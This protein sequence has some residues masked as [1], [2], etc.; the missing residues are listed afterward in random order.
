MRRDLADEARGGAAGRSKAF[1]AAA[2][3]DATM[4]AAPPAAAR[5]DACGCETP[6]ATAEAAL[7]AEAERE[8]AKEE[9]RLLGGRVGCG[10]DG[11]RGAPWRESATEGFDNIDGNPSAKRA[12]APLLITPSSP[13]MYS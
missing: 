6:L 7:A 4:P 1:A 5:R 11:C 2:L 12:L 3:A 13:R 9:R 8:D 10:E